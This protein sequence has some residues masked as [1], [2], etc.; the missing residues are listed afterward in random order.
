MADGDAAEAGLAE[1]G[2]K[3]VGPVDAR[4]CRRGGA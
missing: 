2:E 3:L 1:E 4:G